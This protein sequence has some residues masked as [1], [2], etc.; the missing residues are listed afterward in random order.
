MAKL[1]DILNQSGKPLTR[2]ARTA[3]GDDVNF[4]RCRLELAFDLFRSVFKEEIDRLNEN[5]EK[6]VDMR[7]IAGELA[8]LKFQMRLRLYQAALDAD[9]RAEGYR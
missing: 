8:D 4:V 5:M 1:C 2:Q 3:R 7:D 6:P 9:D